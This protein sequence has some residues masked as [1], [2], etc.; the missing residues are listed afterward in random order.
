MA[1][2]KIVDNDP[3]KVCDGCKRSDPNGLERRNGRLWCKKC[4]ADGKVR[5]FREKKKALNK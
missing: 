2:A 4:I 1:I 3:K 5:P